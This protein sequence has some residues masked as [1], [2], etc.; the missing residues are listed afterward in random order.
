VES[1]DQGPGRHPPNPLGGPQGI[2]N[3]STW[4]KVPMMGNDPSG[5]LPSTPAVSTACTPN[6]IETFREGSTAGGEK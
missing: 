4:V 5:E 6:E 3:V 1:P 2:E